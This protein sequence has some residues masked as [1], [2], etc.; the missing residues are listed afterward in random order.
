MS[1]QGDDR[2]RRRERRP[3]YYSSDDDSIDDYPPPKAM[4]P[5]DSRR[6]ERPGP[7]R[8]DSASMPP[9]PRRPSILVDPDETSSQRAR[10]RPR[11]NSQVRLQASDDESDYDRPRA[12]SNKTGGPPRSARHD[13]ERKVSP[14]QKQFREKRDGYESEEGEMHKKAAPR[15]PRPRVN[16]DDDSRIDE[17]YDRKPRR[18][19]RDDVRG[20]PL[21][22]K[23]RDPADAALAGAAGGAALAAAANPRLQRRR[24]YKGE[25]RDPRYDDDSPPRGADPRDRNED[26]R[27]LS[28][29]GRARTDDRGYR[30][31]DRGYRQ[32]PT[33][34]PPPRRK[35]DDYDDYDDY[36]D[37]DRRRRDGGGYRSDRGNRAQRPP[38]PQDYYSDHRDD[39]ALRSGPRDPRRRDP[40]RDRYRDDDRYRDYD[41][42]RGDDYDRPKSSKRGG[43]PLASFGDSKWQKEVGTAFVAYALPTIKKE[44]GKLLKKE[45]QK[46]LARQQGGDRR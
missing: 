19:P 41:R 22:G 20:L 43:G 9:P 23:P 46:F 8:T 27:Y 13:L 21:R 12:R 29:A 42:R 11:S 14:E 1:T 45:M 44:G 35:E 18:D 10:R 7:E 40:A 26:P 34:R 24:T 30:S 17:P 16:Y 31:D 28:A 4:P 39:R 15:A 2:P 3:R 33:K 5:R 36:G 38:R 37:R 6:R 32:N 25:G